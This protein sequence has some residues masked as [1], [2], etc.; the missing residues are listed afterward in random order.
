M[1]TF[2]DDPG[3]KPERHI[4]IGSKA[5]WYDASD[6]IPQHDEYPPEQ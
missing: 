1:G 3:H 4:F 5:S 6:D 2:D